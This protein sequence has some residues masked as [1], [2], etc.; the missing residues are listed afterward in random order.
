MEAWIPVAVSAFTLIG[1]MINAFYTRQVKV[2]I[3]SRMTELLE[4]T[5]KAAH[6]AGKAEEVA[7]VNA[8]AVVA[9]AAVAAVTAAVGKKRTK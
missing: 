3:N 4:L 8:P 6:A 5:E 9:A 2:H 7:K 1:V